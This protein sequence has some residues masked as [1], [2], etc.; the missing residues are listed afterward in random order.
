MS[1]FVPTI[2]ESLPYTK[3]IVTVFSGRKASLEI[4]CKY[5]RKAISRGHIDEV[6]FWNYTRNPADDAFLKSIASPKLL[7]GESENFEQVNIEIAENGFDFE[8]VNDARVKIRVCD[9]S[10][11]I[12]IS[13]KRGNLFVT[14][15]QFPL[16][17]TIDYDPSFAHLIDKTGGKY[18]VSINNS[19]FVIYKNSAVVYET[20]LADFVVGE[21]Y[22][23]N[24]TYN[25]ETG[26][27]LE[28]KPEVDP[29]FLMQPFEKNS[30]KN[31]YQHYLDPSYTNS[32]IIKCDDDI[33]FI[34]LARLP[35]FISKIRG[36]PELPTPFDIL[37]ANT[38]NN[39]VSA[40]YQQKY[41][42]VI[43]KEIGDFEYPPGGFGGSLWESGEKASILH[44]HF[45]KN[46]ALYTGGDYSDN[47]F[48]EIHSRFSINFFGILGENWYKIADA[49][50]GS[51]NGTDEY[52]ISVAFRENRGLKTVMYSPFYVSHLS[53]YS[54]GLQDS[55]DLLQMYSNLI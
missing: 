16:L 2:V 22:F 24:S 7:C 33:V 38:I 34:D 11:K 5:L 31:Y 29:F 8:V 40:Y 21:V 30:W 12:E 26:L 46:R 20:P 15:N 17:S 37:Y 47:D 52:N 23:K 39:G 32:T 44:R 43:P 14:Y 36:N 4:L 13:L 1:E 53:F 25:S 28:Y 10:N 3:N 55:E 42:Y 18:R 45:V 49:Y 19:R 35:L 9:Q 6:H 48:I 41:L 54:Q 51:D 50:Q 27:L